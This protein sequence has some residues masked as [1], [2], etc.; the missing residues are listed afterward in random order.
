MKWLEAIALDKSISKEFIK[1]LKLEAAMGRCTKVGLYPDSRDTL[2]LANEL[3]KRVKK[4]EKITLHANFGDAE[5]EIPA[6]ELQ[7]SPTEPGLVT[8]TL[9]GH[10]LPFDK[11]TPLTL[12]EIT[13]Q[14]VHVRFASDTYCRVIDFTH[15]K[16]LRIF[17]C[18]GADS[19][20]ATLCKSSNLPLALQS[21]E[22]KHDDDSSGE[23]TTALNTLL[24]LLSCLRRLYIDISN[25]K[26]GPITEAAVTRHGK[27]LT[28]MLIHSYEGD[29]SDPE[30]EEHLFSTEDFVKI[31]TACTKLEQLSVAFPTTPIFRMTEDYARWV[32]AVASSLPKLV[33]LN[34]TTWP[35]NTPSS[36]RLP[37]KAYEWLLQGMAQET[38]EA[39]KGAARL[40]K[41]EELAKAKKSSENNTSADITADAAEETSTKKTK[42]DD[43]ELSVNSKLTT[44]AFGTSDKI[45]ERIDP[46]T[47]IVYMRGSLISPTTPNNPTNAAVPVSWSLRKYEESR[48]DVLDFALARAIRPPCREGIGGS[49]PLGGRG[50]DDG[51]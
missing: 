10:M 11:C 13:L 41:R 33:T 7:D 24:T 45:F 25:A 16:T 19:L 5:I 21:F 46:K 8:R 42:V 27:T 23:A 40:R 20:I 1:S 39:S 30:D 26:A 12:R 35:T 36:T 17:N 37:R 2:Q 3:L 29:P 47:C 9:F 14:N 34:V 18:L 51:W 22:F 15:L 48:S 50:N 44:I 38:F 43:H 6:S 4:I 28:E 32:A 49:S 31:C